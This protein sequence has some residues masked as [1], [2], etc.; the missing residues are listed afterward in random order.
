[1]EQIW[2]IF[3][4]SA[5]FCT[6]PEN[7]PYLC[8]CGL[9]QAHTHRNKTY[10]LK[11][12]AYFL[13]NQPYFCACGILCLSR[14]RSSTRTSTRPLARTLAQ[15]L[16]RTVLRPIFGKIR[17]IFPK[18]AFKTV[19]VRICTSVRACVRVDVRVDE[20]VYEWTREWMSECASGWQSASG[21]TSG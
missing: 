8:T 18:F 7:R 4:R 15:I 11:N 10:F 12:K 9:A 21:C 17:L 5:L 16:T 14:T 3:N 6:C 2:L 1:M 20:R 19:R 13:E